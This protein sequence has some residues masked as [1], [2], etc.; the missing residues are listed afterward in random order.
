M[1]AAASRTFWTAGRRSPMRMAIIAIT[2]SSSIKV[3]PWRRY[4]GRGL[5]GWGSFRRPLFPDRNNA[6][7]TIVVGAPGGQEWMRWVGEPDRQRCSSTSR[8]SAVM[9]DC[10]ACAAL[11]L[12]LVAGLAGGGDE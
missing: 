4:M 5:P 1:R 2:T 7:N 8:E 9:R 10:Q 11:V 6:G 12:T 3:N